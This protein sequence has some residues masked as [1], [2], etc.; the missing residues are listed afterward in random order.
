MNVEAHTINPFRTAVPFWGQTCQISSGLSPKRDCG[1]KGVKAAAG[2]PSTYLP[3]Y[4][5]KIQIMLCFVLVLV[6]VPGT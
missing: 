6:A 2:V 4:M 5:M 3:K 1:S